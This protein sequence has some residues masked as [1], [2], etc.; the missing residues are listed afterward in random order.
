MF[1]HYNFR[2]P[3]SDLYEQG[4]TQDQIQKRYVTAKRLCEDKK[5]VVTLEGK[6]PKYPEDLAAFVTDIYI[7][8]MQYIV[9]RTVLYEFEYKGIITDAKVIDEAFDHGFW[10]E[11]KIEQ[12]GKLISLYMQK[13]TGWNDQTYLVK[14][15]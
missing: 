11:P 9:I 6:I 14:Q 7:S 5:L 3:I 2:I 12:E 10:F 4:W 1:Q 15:K 8:R 13:S